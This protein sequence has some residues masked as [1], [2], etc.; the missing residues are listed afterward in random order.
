MLIWIIAACLQCALLY[1]LWRGARNIILQKVYDRAPETL[2]NNIPVVGMIIPAAGNHPAMRKAF[3]SLLEQDYPHIIP[4][5]VTST[6]DDPAYALA[7][8]LQKEYPSLE[9]ITAGAATQCGQK[10]FNTLKAVEHLGNRADVYVFCDSTHTAKPH[11]VR[12]LVWPII[13]NEAGF[14]TGYHAVVAKDTQSVTLAYQISVLLMRFLQAV[15]LFTQPWGGAMAIARKVF[16][17][18]SIADFWK[19]NVVDDC[20]LA[21]ML[22]ERRLHVQLC[23][24]AILETEAHNHSFSV[25]QAWM[26]RQVLFLKFCV[27]SQWF[28]LGV[29]ALLMTLPVAISCLYII[30]GLTNILPISAGWGTLLA[31][32]HLGL[33]ASIVLRWRELTPRKAPAF[34]WLKAFFLSSGMFLKVYINT[35]QAWHINWHGYRYDVQKGGKVRHMKKL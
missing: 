20:S 27:I 21:S 2:P 10:N 26:Q 1:G 28:L 5:I 18:H 19:D 6:E 14:T 11:F 34:A 4:V 24:H 22:L 12:E 17:K 15:A 25:W 29:F 30:G 23:P 13:T 8:T 35:L 33:L 16:E 9:C 3:T 32:M 31:C 7:T